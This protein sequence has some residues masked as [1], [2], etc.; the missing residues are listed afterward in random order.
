MGN[1]LSQVE[2]LEPAVKR[3]LN[4]LRAGSETKVKRFVYVSSIV[5]AMLNPKWPKDRVKDET[6]W[7]DKEHCRATKVRTREET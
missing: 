7:S 3:T 4:V 2:L 5:A 1:F 6:C